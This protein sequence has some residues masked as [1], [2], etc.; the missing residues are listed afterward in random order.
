MTTQRSIICTNTNTISV[1]IN[2]ILDGKKYDFTGNFLVSLE[3]I[4]EKAIIGTFKKTFL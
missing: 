3:V 4:L 1:K 2:L